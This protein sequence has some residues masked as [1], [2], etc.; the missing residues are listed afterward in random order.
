[1]A[2][3]SSGNASFDSVLVL[4]KHSD[5]SAKFYE[6]LHP[7]RN[8]T[9]VSL[10]TYKATPIKPMEDLFDEAERRVSPEA[11]AQLIYAILQAEVEPTFHK[12]NVHAAMTP[13]EVKSQFEPVFDQAKCLQEAYLRKSQRI[14][15]DE[16]VSVKS[17]TSSSTTA[18][19]QQHTPFVTVI[20]KST[21]Q[22]ACHNIFPP[23]RSFW[24][25]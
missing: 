25:R 20:K 6:Y 22:H 15:A 10:L 21:G 16:P 13:A 14:K 4:C 8:S 11:T 9:V 2:A 17:R 5:N 12:I 24:M 7:M 18:D 3:I 19:L 1:M 23:C